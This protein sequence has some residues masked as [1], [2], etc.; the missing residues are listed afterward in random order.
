MNRNGVIYV[1]NVP[2]NLRSLELQTRGE[3]AIG[4]PVIVQRHFRPIGAGNTLDIKEA[5]TR[6]EEIEVSPAIFYRRRDLDCAIAKTDHP[7]GTDISS[8][9]NRC[10]SSLRKIKSIGGNIGVN[11][12]IDQKVGQIIPI[13][14][15]L[16][17][18]FVDFDLFN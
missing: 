9:L 8:S 1:I 4:A 10:S 17:D 15:Y 3:G 7:I 12:V 2:N 6:I 5:L 16:L 14:L 18:E 11:D 13:R